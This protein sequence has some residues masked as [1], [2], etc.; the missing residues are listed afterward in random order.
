MTLRWTAASFLICALLAQSAR[1]DFQPPADGRFTESQLVAYLD[2]QKDW[3]AE[4]ARI[5]TDATT[6]KT[7]AQKDAA[8]AEIE[9]GYQAC[10]S[11]HHLTRA[12]YDWIGQQ[13]QAA[14]SAG[15]YLAHA[16]G[17]PRQQ[18][19]Q[20]LT[21]I[22]SQ[23]AAAKLRLA[24]YQTARK[25]GWRVLSP[26]DRDAIVRQAQDDAKTASDEAHQHGADADSAAQEAK[27]HD[28]DALAEDQAAANPPSDLTGD[29][30]AAFIENKKS[31]AEADRDA[32]KEDRNQE[33]DD[34][35]DQADAQGRADAALKLVA[36]PEI[37]VSDDK[38]DQADADD[39]IG[40]HDA[41]KDVSGFERQ[42]EGLEKE[43]QG[44]LNAATQMT[45]GAPEE[46]VELMQKYGARYRDQIEAA[47]RLGAAT[48]PSA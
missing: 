31:E 21:R 18:I 32:A 27:D 20:Q 44:V 45:H 13:A 4:S 42:K 39:D 15:I 23:L 3:L 22:E 33:S 7:P 34:R 8:A 2:A 5:L 9:P 29:D 48:R 10:M 36:H 16:D 35:K 47:S 46:N 24:E 26:D 38:R 14:W 1:A 37:P 17:R 28:A 43:R 41:Q 25:N 19:E 12:E 11:R 40:I 30:R 6:A